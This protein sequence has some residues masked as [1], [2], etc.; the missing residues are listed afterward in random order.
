MSL[1]EMTIFMKR[2]RIDDNYEDDTNQISYDYESSQS[3]TE[4]Q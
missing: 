3:G 1:E 2:V 4:Q